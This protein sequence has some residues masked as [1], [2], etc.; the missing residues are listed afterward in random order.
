[1]ALCRFRARWMA[2]GPIGSVEWVH[3][4]ERWCSSMAVHLE[5]NHF[6]PLHL[7]QGSLTY[8]RTIKLTPYRQHQG[9]QELQLDLTF[10]FK[11]S[12]STWTH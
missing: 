5:H 9:L 2:S 3:Q 7:L 10:F 11:K 12:P 6:L 8:I 4:T 1:M